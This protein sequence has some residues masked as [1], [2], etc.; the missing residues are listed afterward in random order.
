MGQGNIIPNNSLFL[1]LYYNKDYATLSY[2]SYL[3][4]RTYI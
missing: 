1:K 3:N 4:I 2:Q